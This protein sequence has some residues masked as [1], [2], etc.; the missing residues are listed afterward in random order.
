MRTG[1]SL[2]PGGLLLPYHLGALQCLHEEGRL[3]HDASTVAVAGS[4][5]GAIATLA[6]G[7]G[8]HMEDVLEATIAVSDECHKLGK[9]QGN[10]LPLLQ[11][12]MDQLVGEKEFDYL[13][14]TAGISQPAIGMAY[15][16]IFPF[17]QQN[18]LQTTFDDREDLF[19]AVSFS[20]MFPFFSTNLPCY[21]DTHRGILQSR[22]MVDGFF[23]VPRD[24][25]GCPDFDMLCDDSSVTL[26]DDDDNG[27]TEGD[28]KDP[29]TPLVDRTVAICCFPQS[30]MGVTAFDPKDCISPDRSM[31]TRSGD[32]S[33]AGIFEIATQATSR[34]KLTKAFRLGYINA[35]DWCEQ[36]AKALG[37]N[38]YCEPEQENS[39]SVSR[40]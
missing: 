40:S 34:Q 24:R 2:S 21:W 30:T 29:K 19:R 6:Q 7:C 13:T 33:M 38:M 25:L 1:F 18:Y 36:E 16:Q 14:S 39:A 15:R 11:K 9:A 10:L 27:D 17:P 37:G 22:L 32:W 4:S 28:L 26:D 12:Q 35:G 20:C 5:A 3:R 8:L 31:G 23:T